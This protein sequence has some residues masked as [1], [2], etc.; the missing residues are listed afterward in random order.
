MN[1][2]APR[3]FTFSA[4][5][6]GD[7]RVTGITAIRG[8]GLPPAQRLSVAPTAGP[9]PT[10]WLRGITSN[11]RYVERAEKDQLLARQEGLGRA[12]STLACLIPI[13]KSAAWWAM[14]QDERR[15]VFEAD[16]NHTAIGLRYLPQVARRLHHCRDLGEAEPFDFLTWFEYAPH[17][18]AAFDELLAS[19]RA[20]P[21]WTF[22]EREVEVRLARG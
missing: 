19:L 10:W 13:R 7:W 1:A 21:E 12:Q 20:T 5:Q 17:D 9:S 6:A 3:L 14:T 15:R 11:E 4:G 2:P 16:S 18:E 8:D 22:V